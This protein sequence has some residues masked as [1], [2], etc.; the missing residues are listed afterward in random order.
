MSQH[1]ELSAR[2]PVAVPRQLPDRND[3]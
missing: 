2:L 1:A 3:H